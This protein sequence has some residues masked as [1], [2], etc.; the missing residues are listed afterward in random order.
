MAVIFGTGGDSSA[1]P[2]GK[3]T[4]SADT[5]CMVA[6]V[7]SRGHHRDGMIRKLYIGVS[8]LPLLAFAGVLYWMSRLEGWGALGLVPLIRWVVVAS[9]VLGA[10][11]VALAVRGW[12]RGEQVLGLALAAGLAGSVALAVGVLMLVQEL[13]RSF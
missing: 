6:L 10:I 4:I 3:K 1:K 9:A 2:K 11:G 5:C 13:Q 7:L 12:R 8:P